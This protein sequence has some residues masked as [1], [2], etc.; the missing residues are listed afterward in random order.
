MHWR[1]LP[2]RSTRNTPPW[3]VP[4]GSSPF[5]VA[6]FGNEGFPGRFG[7]LGPFA[8]L[9]PRGDHMI[10]ALILAK[11]QAQWL[12]SPKGP[13]AVV[14]GFDKGQFFS[15]SRYLTFHALPPSKRTF[16]CPNRF[17]LTDASGNPN[18]LGKENPGVSPEAWAIS[19]PC[20]RYPGMGQPPEGS[21]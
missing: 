13:S 17:G 9:V 3:Y 10:S 7:E 6:M 4:R 16:G 12:A 21:W 2:Q 5:Q 15:Q 20:E 1:R 11:P 8:S 14:R 19:P 18:G